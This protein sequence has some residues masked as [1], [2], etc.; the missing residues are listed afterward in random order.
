MA[1]GFPFVYPSKPTISERFETGGEQTSWQ[2]GRD[3]TLLIQ[4]DMA[5]LLDLE[6]VR[7][8]ALNATGTR[9]LTLALQYGQDLAVC[10]VA[11]EHGVDEACVRADWAKLLDKLRPRQLLATHPL[12]RRRVQPGRLSLWL[13]LALAWLSLRLL[14]WARTIRCWRRG[15]MSA[16]QVWQTGLTPM[17]QHLDQTVRGVAATHPLNAQCKE[18]AL[19]AWHILRN[20][21]GFAAELVVGVLAYPFEAHAWV[22]CGPLTATDSQ[23]HCEMYTPAARYS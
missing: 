20:R 12:C 13:L 3:V 11:G 23:A 1:A 8:Y 15:R 10:Q 9:L 6:R 7:F 2:L 14:G 17:V 16:T 22:E 4:D 19:V 18:R 5:R 21:W